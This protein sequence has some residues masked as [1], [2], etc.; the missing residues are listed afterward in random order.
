M[1]RRSSL[2]LAVVGALALGSL[3]GCQATTPG[4]FTR[5]LAQ[6]DTA[7][8]TKQAV[9]AAASSAPTATTKL[10]G[11]EAC[12]SDTGFF[13]TSDEWRT[14]T[15]I[16]VSSAQQEAATAAIAGAFTKSGWTETRPR[17]LVTL[18]GGA[19]GKRKGLITV[20]TAGPTALAI[21]VE[22]GCYA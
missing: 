3:A 5:A 11:F 17:G 8:W 9:N 4:S 14:I 10:S 20:Q 1:T 13:T 16:A 7:K 18:K 12:R 6:A 2:A 22:S 15:D 19:T 21:T